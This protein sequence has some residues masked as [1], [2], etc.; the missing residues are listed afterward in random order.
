MDW[1]IL[2]IKTQIH[3]IWINKSIVKH[4]YNFYFN[5]HI[6]FIF[7]FILIAA[8]TFLHAQTNDKPA[9]TIKT[10]ARADIFFIKPILR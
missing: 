10:R 2:I 9:S 5:T 1:L 8:V 7:Y 6:G 4:F 3:I